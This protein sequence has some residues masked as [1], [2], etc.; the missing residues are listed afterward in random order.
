MSVSCA[1]GDIVVFA[2]G[3]TRNANLRN[4][5]RSYF[6]ILIIGI[7]IFVFM[8]MTGVWAQF[9]QSVYQALNQIAGQITRA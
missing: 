7:V 8:I 3:G 1:V 4:F 6:C 2:L 9:M 5:A